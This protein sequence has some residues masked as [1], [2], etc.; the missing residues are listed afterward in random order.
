[1]I[2]VLAKLDDPSDTTLDELSQLVEGMRR[3]NE[4]SLKLLYESTV[5]RL[6]ALARAILR[7]PADAEE[8][9]CA[10]H[11]Q[12]WEGAGSVWSWPVYSRGIEAAT[13]KVPIAEGRSATVV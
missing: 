9:V 10:T 4:E 3:R 1:M 5:S 11:V 7:N 13:A 2:D 8:V 6:H 12:A